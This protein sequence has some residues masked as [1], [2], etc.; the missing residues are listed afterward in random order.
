MIRF[1]VS[2]ERVLLGSEDIFGE[3]PRTMANDDFDKNTI[4]D[5][6]FLYEFMTQLEYLFGIERKRTSAFNLNLC[7]CEF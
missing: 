4:Q 7:M 2:R 3:A 6:L 5:I 1:V